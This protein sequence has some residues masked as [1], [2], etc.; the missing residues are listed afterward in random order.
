MNIT[1]YIEEKTHSAAKIG[2]RKLIQFV[3]S[4]MLYYSVFHAFVCI[5]LDI[6]YISL[7]GDF[8][9]KCIYFQV[10]IRI[11]NYIRAIVIDIA[12]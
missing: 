2:A 3:V 5:G 10:C 7:H 6:L 4:F 1:L 12:G 8:I 9:H 11:W